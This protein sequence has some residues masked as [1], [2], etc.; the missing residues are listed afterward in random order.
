MDKLGLLSLEN[1]IIIKKWYR[2]RWLLLPQIMSLCYVNETWPILKLR[3]YDGS[4]IYV[5]DK[6]TQLTQFYGSTYVHICRQI[7]QHKT[8]VKEIFVVIN[9][10]ILIN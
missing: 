5:I 10:T 1:L 7:Q 6:L 4:M 3:T 2:D 9:I 8:N